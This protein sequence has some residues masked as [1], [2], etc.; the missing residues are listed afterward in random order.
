MQKYIDS[1]QKIIS[2]RGLTDHT[3]KS[4]TSYL[5]AYFSYVNSFLHKL[6]EDV[7][8]DELREY[9][10]Y[11]KNTKC[12]NPRSINAHISQLRFFYLYVLHLPWDSYQIPF[13]KFN[14]YLPTILSQEDV[15]YF[16]HSL[17]NLKHKAVIAT[18]YSAGLRVG[19]VCNLRYEDINRKNMTIHVT[20]SKNRSDRYAIL[21]KNTLD[22]LTEYW[23]AYGRP[24]GWLFPSTHNSTRPIVT[25]TVNRFVND[26]LARLGWNNKI[27]CHSFRHCFGTHLYEN[28]ADLMTVKNLLGHKS[29]NSTIIYVHLG[30]N[31]K[32]APV[33]PF[34]F[35]D[36]HE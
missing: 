17:K 32:N 28:G 5:N 6:P 19:E 13:L 2:L 16:I 31:G 1:F 4:Y 3:L 14:T 27:N 10:F 33:S 30:T 34:D 20:H 8:W 22:I 25:F 23:Y 9:V 15:R 7:S 11:L 12:L 21:S 35:G 36:P 26:H 29:L 18:M 24:T